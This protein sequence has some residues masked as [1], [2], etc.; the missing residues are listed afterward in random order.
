MHRRETT[1]RAQTQNK[2]G[3]TQWWMKQ[4][5]DSVYRKQNCA[6][7]FMANSRDSSPFLISDSS[8]VNVHGAPLSPWSIPLP[9]RKGTPYPPLLELESQ[10]WYHGFLPFEDIA[11][12]LHNDGDF[13]IRAA[14]PVGDKP[15]VP[16]ITAKWG[17]VVDYPIHYRIMGENRLFTLDGNFR[18]P[19]IAELI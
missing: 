8:H 1:L 7:V 13:L 11:G 3:I 9:Y 15:P 6:H 17:E 4:F 10:V 18:N 16:C 5:N 12:L 14:D 19:D 2:K